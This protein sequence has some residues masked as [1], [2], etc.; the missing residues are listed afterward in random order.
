MGKRGAA[1]GTLGRPSGCEVTPTV[2][3]AL[4]SQLGKEVQNVDSA[5]SKNK[6]TIV[7]TNTQTGNEPTKP[8]RNGESVALASKHI[9]IHAGAMAS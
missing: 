3:Y 7:H 9:R 1:N 2:R 8:T 5:K 4:L 6:P